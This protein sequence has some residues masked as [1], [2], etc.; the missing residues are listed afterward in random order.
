ML[1]GTA[2]VSVYRVADARSAD[3][4]SISIC[5]NRREPRRFL[6]VRLPSSSPHDAG[7]GRGLRRGAAQLDERKEPPLP[8]P[9]LHPMEERECLVAAGPRYAVSQVCN[10]RIVGK[11]GR[12]GND[13]CPAD[14][15][16][17]IPQIENLRYGTHVPAR[18]AVRGPYEGRNACVT[19]TCGAIGSA[20][21]DAVG[22]IAA[23]C[24]YLARRFMDR[25]R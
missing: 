6:P 25:R 2:R 3:L 15:K 12:L 20:R 11:I 8:G 5:R 13:R 21:S 9:L 17:A 19:W 10:L 14:Y 16:S 23:R 4:K 7:V 24:P 22:Y 1:A 18:C